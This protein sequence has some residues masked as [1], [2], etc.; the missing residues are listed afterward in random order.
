E[1]SVA[2]ELS[3]LHKT[4]LRI[5]KEYNYRQAECDK[6]ENN[7]GNICELASS[8][9]GEISAIESEIETKRA[10]LD[11]LSEQLLKLNTHQ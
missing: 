7:L 11:N 2:N 3:G 4:L 1:T 8:Q 9:L 10:Y 6:Q 5:K